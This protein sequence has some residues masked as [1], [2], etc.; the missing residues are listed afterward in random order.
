MGLF[1][2]PYPVINR[3][4]CKTMYRPFACRP[5]D[6]PFMRQ[7]VSVCPLYHNFQTNIIFPDVQENLILKQMQTENNGE[8][9]L[10]TEGPGGIFFNS[11]F[12]C[13][14][15]YFCFFPPPGFSL[16]WFCHTSP[17]SHGPPREKKPLTGH[18]DR[19]PSWLFCVPRRLSGLLLPAWL[20]LWGC[21]KAESLLERHSGAL[22][23]GAADV[24]S[25]FS[26][27]VVTHLSK[28]RTELESSSR[29]SIQKFVQQLI[30]FHELTSASSLTQLIILFSV[31][32]R[33]QCIRIFTASSDAL[34]VL[35][36]HQLPCMIREL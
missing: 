28:K 8:A 24:K 16:I 13:C 36:G 25:F 11:L 14:R 12:Y 18:S 21:F 35:F 22:L 30:N 15:Y 31:S 7:L 10:E 17:L 20:L 6:E 9:E 19:N 33:K 4:K 26:Q 29:E 34:F 23:R 3:N 27:S 2:L 32:P 5:S 1:F